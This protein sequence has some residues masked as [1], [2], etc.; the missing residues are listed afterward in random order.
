[1]KIGVQ[2]GRTVREFGIEETYKMYA[3]CGFESVD[4][5][6]NDYFDG[7]CLR[8]DGPICGGGIFEKSVDEIA[9]F[10]QSELDAI[11]KNGL[12]VNQAH[13]P[14]PCYITGKPETLDYMIGIYKN[15]IE[16]CDRVD[17]KYLVIHGASLKKNNNSQSLED[18]YEIN[19]KL[20]SS[21]IPTLKNTN[22]TVCLE[23]LFARYDKISYSAGACG[24]P[25]ET[26]ELID[27]L[28]SEA[29]KECFGLCLDTGHLNLLR[30]DC[31]AYIPVLGNRIKALHIHDNDGIT[32]QHKAPYTGD[33]NFE[34]FCEELKKINYN[35]D[36]SFE[37]F[38]QTTTEIMGKEM[39]KPWFKLIC[40]AGEYFKNKIEKGIN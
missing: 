23:N 16:Y 15:I 1:M 9:D 5:N 25:Y 2:S 39:V 8:K 21:L 14:F 19:Y 10:L 33:F 37:T 24:N 11:H 38:M 6:I 30:I 13:A 22:V 29:G 31:R 34:T 26:A 18:I 3:D 28:N 40:S 7:S 32:D 27:K 36:L 35:G 17:C 4:W 12:T 20:Y